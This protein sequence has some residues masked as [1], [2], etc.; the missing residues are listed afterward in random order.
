MLKGTKLLFL[1]TTIEIV[2]EWKAKEIN[3]SEIT[4]W[5][6]STYERYSYEWV[7]IQDNPTLQQY[8]NTLKISI[9]NIKWKR[10][11][12]WIIYEY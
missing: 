3:T 7:Q 2:G 12:N 6:S 11:G 9:S 8:S 4:A 5:Q 1:T 10:E